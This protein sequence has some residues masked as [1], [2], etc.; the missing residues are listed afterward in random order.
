MDVACQSSN[1]LVDLIRALR[2]CRVAVIGDVMLDRYVE[3]RTDRLSP[4]APIQILDVT[5]EYQMPGGAANV[6]IKAADLGSSVTIVGLGGGDAASR[7]LRGAARR[8]RSS[9]R[10]LDCGS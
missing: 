2:P 10:R 5:D 1:E 6:A 8:P 4:E 7:D 9:H 3:G